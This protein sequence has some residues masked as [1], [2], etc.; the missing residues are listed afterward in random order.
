VLRVINPEGWRPDGVLSRWWLPDEPE[1][2]VIYWGDDHRHQG[3]ARAMAELGARGEIHHIT[4]NSGRILSKPKT[5]SHWTDGEMTVFAAILLT[6][7]ARLDMGL[8][9]IDR[10]DLD[11][12]Q[13]L[14]IEARLSIVRWRQKDT[15]RPPYQFLCLP[16]RFPFEVEGPRPIEFRAA[17]DSAEFTGFAAGTAVVLWGLGAARE[18]GLEALFRLQ[19][20][21]LSEGVLGFTNYVPRAADWSK[22]I[23]RCRWQP[24]Q[25]DNMREHDRLMLPRQVRVTN[26]NEWSIRSKLLAEYGP[27]PGSALS[28]DIQLSWAARASY[29]RLRIDDED[30]VD[31]YDNVEPVNSPLYL[32][33]LLET[34]R[35]NPNLLITGRALSEAQATELAA[36]DYQVVPSGSMLS[37]WGMG[38]FFAPEDV[39]RFAYPADWLFPSLVKPVDLRLRVDSLNDAATNLAPATAEAWGE[40]IPNFAWAWVGGVTPPRKI[41][42]AFGVGSVV[43]VADWTVFADNR[44]AAGDP[45]GHGVA[46]ALRLNATEPGSTEWEALKEALAEFEHEYGQQP[47]PANPLATHRLGTMFVD[48]SH[49]T[50]A[51]VPR[52]AVLFSEFRWLDSTEEAYD[53][54]L[55]AVPP[56]AY[57]PGMFLLGEP[58]D[59]NDRGQ[60]LYIAHARIPLGGD[61]Y[62][63]VVGSRPI[64]VQDFRVMPSAAV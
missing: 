28:G 63:Y 30:D 32:R 42:Q 55:G 23:G 18:Q 61:T 45:M 7:Q 12:E 52:D 4:L 9:F 46:L 48:D 5:A 17:D 22:R 6:V 35:V 29:H 3:R 37:G 14:E 26:P 1:N 36:Y 64:T 53:Y 57:R 51:F 38:D 54:A 47:D 56:A 21:L 33:A 25:R 19:V 24:T 20:H 31:S 27:N 62:R 10:E 39:W 40:R 13:V 15:P 59:H 34:A 41:G 11:H 60:G 8:V 49:S 43:T 50:V 16:S 58:M 2:A 44:Q